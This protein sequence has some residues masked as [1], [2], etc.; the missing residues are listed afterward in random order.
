VNIS[1]WRLEAVGAASRR[2]VQGEMKGK[3]LR[4][5]IGDETGANYSGSPDFDGYD[6]TIRTHDRKELAIAPGALRKRDEL[7]RKRREK[8]E[9]KLHRRHVEAIRNPMGLSMGR[10]GGAGGGEAMSPKSKMR[11]LTEGF[12]ALDPKR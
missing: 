2:E 11:G 5:V 4:S 6:T 9:W 7:V 10:T 12:R 3:S 1:L 8:E